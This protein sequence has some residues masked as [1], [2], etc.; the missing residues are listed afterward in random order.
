MPGRRST[1]DVLL[2]I[3][4]GA[5]IAALFLP[6]CEIFGDTISPLGGV[7]DPAVRRFA[8]PFYL[9]A[10]ISVA[11]ALWI[12]RG[13]LAP[14]VRA[15]AYAL[16]AVSA[17]VTLSLVGPAL[18]G[19]DYLNIVEIWPAFAVLAVFAAGLLLL[20]RDAIGGAPHG[21]HPVMAMQLAYAANAVLCLVTAAPA[22][23]IGAYLV[24]ATG[25]AYTVQFLTAVRQSTTDQAQGEPAER[26]VDFR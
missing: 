24:V 25:L 9:A 2:S 3:A 23:R 14:G 8:A 1:F 15:S 11:C 16:S 10:P 13:R 6:F 26:E 4:G 20:I 21:L 12:I 7:I 22:W 5:G 19:G 17:A 18:T